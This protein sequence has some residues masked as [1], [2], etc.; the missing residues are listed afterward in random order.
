M[1]NQE[2]VESNPLIRS[3]I[4]EKEATPLPDNFVPG[5]LDVKSGRG[6]GNWA[7]KGNQ[8]FRRVICSNLTRFESATTKVERSTIVESVLHDLRER[9]VYFVKHTKKDGWFDVGNRQAK[10]KI[11]TSFRYYSKRKR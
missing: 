5:E 2:R 10:D 4:D 7:H 8:D 6:K 3:T 9:G 1:E 11:S